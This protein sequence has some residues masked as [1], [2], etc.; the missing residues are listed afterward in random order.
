[1]CIGDTSR[2]ILENI[3]GL[4]FNFVDKVKILGFE[5]SNTQ[6]WNEN[7]IQNATKKVR[8]LVQFWSR[9]RLSLIGKITIYKT[10]LMPQINFLSTIIMPTNDSIIHEH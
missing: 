6:Q 2:N 9:F 4:G 3:L 8:K 1:M 10:L 5:V 7:N